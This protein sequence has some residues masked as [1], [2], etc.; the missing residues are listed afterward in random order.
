MRRKEDSKMRNMRQRMKGRKINWSPYRDNA[1]NRIIR[2]LFPLIPPDHQHHLCLSILAYFAVDGG[3]NRA[4]SFWDYDYDETTPQIKWMTGWLQDR[5]RDQGIN[6]SLR[7]RVSWF[8]LIAGWLGSGDLLLLLLLIS[9]LFLDKN[10]FHSFTSTEANSSG[11]TS[12]FC[13]FVCP[14]QLFDWFIPVSRE[15]CIP[16]LPAA[17]E[18][19]SQVNGSFSI[20]VLFCDL[21]WEEIEEDFVRI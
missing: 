19:I 16:S 4:S 11:A 21:T 20:S 10:S 14:S 5:R 12:Q 13:L 17:S 3:D 2:I 9:Y 8:G 6:S 7:W 1:H 18:E 15:Y